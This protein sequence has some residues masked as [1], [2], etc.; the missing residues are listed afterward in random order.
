V[1]E[2]VALKEMWGLNI[3]RLWKVVKGV[4]FILNIKSKSKTNN[5]LTL[6]LA[7]LYCVYC[8]LIHF[9]GGNTMQMDRKFRE[10]NI[11]SIQ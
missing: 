10:E 3:R 6:A 9:G 11:D 8:Y 4:G 5:T 7:L 2:V 1:I